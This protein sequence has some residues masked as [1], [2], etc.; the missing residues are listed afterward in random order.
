LSF[1]V[2]LYLV[3]SVTNSMQSAIYTLD[4]SENQL[5]VNGMPIWEFY[6][7]CLTASLGSAIWDISGLSLIFLFGCSAGIS[8][9][10]S[11]TKKAEWLY[12]HEG[13]HPVTQFST[14]ALL[15]TASAALPYLIFLFVKLV[16]WPSAMVPVPT[17][18][19]SML[20]DFSSGFLPFGFMCLLAAPAA[21]LICLLGDRLENRQEEITLLERSTIS[22]VFW[23][24]LITGIFVPTMVRIYIGDVN[25]PQM[26]L[27]TIILPTITLAVLA[28]SFWIIGF[29]KVKSNGS[30][31]HPWPDSGRDHSTAPPNDQNAMDRKGAENSPAKQETSSI[32]GSTAEA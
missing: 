11:L 12:R 20:R 27:L 23:F 29:D 7:S 10:A 8:Y 5:L 9:R 21:I 14:V 6:M 31:E 13:Q 4:D 22:L 18:F 28:M 32:T 26:T 30:S 16:V 3:L 17:H 15:A 19:A 2:V 24:S 1:S 25:D